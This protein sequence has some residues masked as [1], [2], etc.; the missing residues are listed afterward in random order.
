MTSDVER[1]VRLET[2]TSEHGRRLSELE[3]GQK[4]IVSQ[5]S[6]ARSDIRSV[7]ERVEGIKGEI[8]KGSKRDKW[9]IGITVAIVNAIVDILVIL[10]H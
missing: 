6:D 3:T 5:V 10:M 4:E 1:L 9:I 7:G 2:Q 8:I